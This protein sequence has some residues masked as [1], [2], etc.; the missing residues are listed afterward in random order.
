MTCLHQWVWADVMQ[1]RLLP[2]GWER[3]NGMTDKWRILWGRISGVDLPLSVRRLKAPTGRGVKSARWCPRSLCAIFVVRD[4]KC[5]AVLNRPLCHWASLP[6]TMPRSAPYSP[7]RILY[8]MYNN[9][10]AFTMIIIFVF[11]CLLYSLFMILTLLVQCLFK[12]I[13][14]TGLLNIYLTI[15]KTLQGFEEMSHFHS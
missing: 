1:S 14:T 6:F 9:F 3:Y 5:A 15:L 8:N 11:F 10:S 13:P 12:P 2:H 7:T 4:A